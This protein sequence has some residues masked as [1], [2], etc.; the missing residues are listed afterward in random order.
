MVLSKVRRSVMPFDQNV[1][2]PP[3]PPG[4]PHPQ[5]SVHPTGPFPV[6]ASAFVPES[7]G[8]GI[9]AMSMTAAPFIPGT[10]A[11][12]PHS[13]A[14][15]SVHGTP[16][17]QQVLSSASVGPATRC[18]RKWTRVHKTT[19]VFG[20]LAPSFLLAKFFSTVVFFSPS[21]SLLLTLAWR[22]SPLS[23]PLV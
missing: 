21:L 6:G 4:A 13:L 1:N 5:R 10:S 17:A 23:H 8:H 12:A 19:S 7:S 22:K 3:P 11:R 15:A 20:F 18:R 9:G 14:S 16:Q 2:V